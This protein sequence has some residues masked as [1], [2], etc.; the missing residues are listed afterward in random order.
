MRTLIPKYN[1]KCSKFSAMNPDI[2]KEL[3]WNHM[4]KCA[5]KYHIN[6]KK[7]YTIESMTM[8][9]TVVSNL[10]PI[11]VNNH[12]EFV[13]KLRAKFRE[14]ANMDLYSHEIIMDIIDEYVEQENETEQP[15]LR[16]SLEKIIDTYIGDFED[17]SYQ[18]DMKIK[19]VCFEDADDD[20]DAEE[21]EDRDLSEIPEIIDT[22]SE[23]DEMN[24][25][26]IL[27]P[28]NLSELFDSVSST[29][30]IITN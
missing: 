13:A 6:Q 24:C 25:A 20:T 11:I 26:V 30:N 19:I 27:P 21:E 3:F 9:G 28:L 5:Q 7:I 2:L 16:I 10:E 15:D 17:G 18:Y 8:N 14:A 12:Y 1:Y 22:D 4:E 23:S 29:W